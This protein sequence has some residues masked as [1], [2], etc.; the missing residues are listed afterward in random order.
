MAQ[1]QGSK[2]TECSRVTWR[3]TATVNDNLL[4]KAVAQVTEGVSVKMDRM[5]A[6][7]YKNDAARRCAS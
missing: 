7:A 2:A 1:S 5:L 3:V 4:T 6:E